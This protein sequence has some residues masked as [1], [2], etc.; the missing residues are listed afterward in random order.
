MAQ[1]SFKSDGR[2]KSNDKKVLRE[3]CNELGGDI[4]TLANKLEVKVFVEEL[5]PYDSGYLEYAPTCGSASNFRIVVNSKQSPERQRF[6]VAHEL[7]HYLLHKDD[8]EFV[9]RTETSHRS[10]D[11]FE[12]LESE[13]VRMEREANAFAA[14]LLMPPNLFVPACQQLNGDSKTIAKLFFV[15]EQA[16]KIRIMA[17]NL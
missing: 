2:I 11:P 9:F 5:W 10:D 15:S 7:A 8:P 1:L 14:A 3:F 6:T 16:V 13:D 12:Y 17:L 4:V